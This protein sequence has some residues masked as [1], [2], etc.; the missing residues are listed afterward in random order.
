MAS[1]AGMT[2]V[3]ARKNTELM[4][5]SFDERSVLRRHCAPGRH[6]GDPLSRSRT[7]SD[8]RELSAT[9]N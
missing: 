4:S 6:T 5:G 3:D 1:S 7:A 2:Q 8:A 9:P